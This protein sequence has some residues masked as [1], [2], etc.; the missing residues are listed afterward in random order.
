MAE[1]VTCPA[2][3][4]GLTL[5]ALPKGQTVQCPRCQHIFEPGHI[6]PPRSFTVPSKPIAESAAN[7]FD[8]DLPPVT[9]Y[10]PLRG[11]WKAWAAIGLLALSVLSYCLQ[12]YVNYERTQVIQLE[13]RVHGPRNHFL[14]VDLLGPQFLDEQKRPAANIALERR[15]IDLNQ[16]SSLANN[17]HHL[18]YWPAAIMVLI[19]LH[20]ASWTL[21]IL[22]CDGI[23]FSPSTAVLSFFIPVMNLLQPYMIVQEIWRASDP[24]VTQNAR[25]WR[26]VP[27]SRMVMAW[28]IALLAAAVL[29]VAARW[30]CRDDAFGFDNDDRLLS[31]RVWCLSN[32]GMLVAGSLL[33]VIIRGIH[34]R[35]RGRH[36]RIYDDVHV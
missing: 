10:Q 17:L 34:V 4:A 21:R 19:W 27:A 23:V 29:A 13:N 15:E 28:W 33:I 24:G 22:R 14:G 6:S 9:R 18:T 26:F 3:Q 32:M 12:L 16:L 35:Q 8:Y 5:P 2:C 36:A 30:I 31:A 25:S 20:Q 11:Q 7:G 1:T